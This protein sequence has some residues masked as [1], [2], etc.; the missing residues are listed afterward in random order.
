MAGVSRLDS[1]SGA[2]VNSAD[3]SRS[4]ASCW[5]TQTP[6]KLRRL[7]SKLRFLLGDLGLQ[8]QQ[9]DRVIGRLLEMGVPCSIRSHRALAL[10]RKE[11]RPWWKWA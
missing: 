8:R 5:V 10:G 7:E 6:S 2:R 1:G 11:G 9:R 3:W 4:C